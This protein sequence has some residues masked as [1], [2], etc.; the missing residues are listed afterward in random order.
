[1]IKRTWCI[2][3]MWGEDGEIEKG[4]N[5]KDTQVSILDT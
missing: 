4:K 1:M 3:G 5:Q 2:K